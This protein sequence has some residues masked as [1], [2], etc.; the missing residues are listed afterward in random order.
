MADA[1]VI[2]VKASNGG[3][4]QPPTMTALLIKELVNQTVDQMGFRGGRTLLRS[5]TTV[6]EAVRADD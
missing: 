6:K 5:S 4:A 3:L 1:Q 2:V